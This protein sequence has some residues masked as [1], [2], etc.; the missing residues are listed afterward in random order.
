MNLRMN[1]SNELADI[2]ATLSADTNCASDG[3]NWRMLWQRL[4]EQRQ[5]AIR[6]AFDAGMRAREAA[7]AKMALQTLNG[8]R[9]KAT[10]RR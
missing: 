2:H 6:N 5:E 7:H 9:R 8:C 3:R 4:C 1:P 10:A